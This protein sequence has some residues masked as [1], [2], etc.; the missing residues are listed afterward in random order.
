MNDADRHPQTSAV[1]PAS[2]TLRSLTSD[3]VADQ[4]ETYLRHLHEAVREDRNRNIALTGPYG[5][6]KSS[7]LDQ[8]AGEREE[9]HPKTT[10]RIAISTLGPDPEGV[11]RML[12]N[13]IQKELVK[14]LLY[15]A[16]PRE[17]SFSRF[18]RIVPLSKTRAALEASLIVAVVGGFLFLLG[19]LPQLKG[20]GAGN[21]GWIVTLSWLGFA[22]LAVAALAILRKVIHGSA[23]SDVSAAGATVKLTQQ[24]STYF[25]EYLDEIVYFFDTKLPELVI[26]EDLDRFDDPHIFEAL[27]ELNTLLNHTAKRRTRNKPLR[28]VYAIKD[29][30]FETLGS[31]PGLAPQ[32]KADAETVRANRTKFFD[33]VIP[34]VP[35]ISHR[36]AR[37]LLSGLLDSGKIN[38]IDRPLIALVAEHTT[39]MRLLKNI[40]NEY[41]VFAER[42]LLSDKKA[43]GLT[44]SNLFAL[45]AYKNLHLKDFELISRRES[46]LDLLYERRRDL[47]RTAIDDRE[48]RKRELLKEPGR[49]EARAPLAKDMGDRLVAIGHAFKDNNSTTGGWRDVHFQSA[50][51]TWYT[52]D[53]VHTCDF[54]RTV[55]ESGEVSIKASTGQFGQERAI[56]KLGS[57][58]I[59]ALFPE[60]LEVAKWDELDKRAHRAAIGELDKEI[61]YLR[62]ADFKHLVAE[63]KYT[64]RTEQGDK[65]F[66]EIVSRTVTSKLARKL[67]SEGYLDRNFALYASQFY[68]DFTGVDV[69]RFIVHSVQPNKMDVQHAF[70]GPDAIA[71][72][73]NEAPQDFPRTVSAYNIQVVD[74]LLE[75]KDARAS[76]IAA[77]VV[78]DFGKDA[79]EFLKAYLNGGSRREEFVALLSGFPWPAVITYLV[80][81]EGVPDDVRPAL[82]NAALSGSLPAVTYDP[83]PEVA[84]FIAARYAE[85]SVFTSPQPDAIV[86]KVAGFLKEAAIVLPDL[87]VLTE[88]IREHVVRERL[89][90]ITAGNLRQVVGDGDI[91]LDRVRQ[92]AHVWFHC[93]QN[94]SRYLT[95]VEND[96]ATR[97]AIRSAESLTDVLNGM[98]SASDDAHLDRLFTL[99]AP[100]S[101]VER[102]DSVPARYWRRLAAHRLFHANLEN[103]VAYREKI[104]SI[105]Q[106]L[107]DLI[108][109]AGSI[110]TVADT[111]HDKR[112][113]IA[114]DILNAS[115]TIPDPRMRVHLAVRLKVTGF[116]PVTQ[117]VTDGGEFL[118]LL[119]EEELIEDSAEAFAHFRDEGWD[120]IG[121][122][123]AKSSRFTEFM[124]PELV[125]GFVL[126]MFRDPDVPPEALDKVVGNL[127]QYVP[128]DDATVLSAAGN[129]AWDREIELPWDQ[130]RRI[131][132]ATLDA[133][134]TI[135][136]LDAVQYRPSAA[137][138]VDVLGTLGEPY[139]YLSNHA[140]TKFEV[141]ND[142]AHQRVF[143][144][145]KREGAIAEVTK[146]P[147][148]DSRIV[149]L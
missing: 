65:N 72:L 122:A 136:L 81:E 80:Q 110:S 91:S 12:T 126:K 146:A 35:F 90:L 59:Q 141:P 10:L 45:I 138:V 97:Y 121:P 18:K 106:G 123:I 46:D 140:K 66:A 86:T 84:D 32:D 85:M 144:Y 137:D 88:A 13:R 64:L 39:D 130:L 67:V 100:D 120:A 2:P 38:R 6:G 113:S 14:Q 53:E 71:D 104:G 20:A 112:L 58:R 43:P 55:A 56:G 28:F 98:D 145:L 68:G 22:A 8:F 49:I 48:R 134:L 26:F 16:S 44:A 115:D 127:A 40:C 61:A 132:S 117:I 95:A 139:S 69:A 50:G 135:R 78:A 54:W 107:A 33:I 42:L 37:E 60:S 73:L 27:R 23:I 111:D 114:V 74:H 17:M 3:Y 21:S 4:H 77:T 52:E 119:L 142:I 79:R 105:D 96:S 83:N 147:R 133:N 124:T 93:V 34:M 41:T 5:S 116:L 82:V 57:G 70:S 31:E 131:A 63:G 143:D 51:D 87:S 19:W 129:H 103:V 101:A 109:Q 99:T 7:V 25:D 149:K 47:V 36:N 94:P 1:L 118:A 75:R 9:K 92:N 15:R 102:L 148:R 11:D 108:V 125:R 128:G 89:Y 24:T 30:L 62:A 76:E 29:S